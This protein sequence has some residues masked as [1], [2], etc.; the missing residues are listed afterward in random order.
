MATILWQGLRSVTPAVLRWTPD[1][2]VGAVYTLTTNAK[3][4][5][6]T[7]VTGNTATDVAAGIAAAAQSSAEPEWAELAV[8]SAA[9]VLSVTGP[10]DGAPITVTAGVTGGGS[11]TA[12]TTT[13]ATSPHD[14][15]DAANYAGGALPANS[16]TLVFPAQTADVRYR[17][18]ALQALT[19]LTV[20]REVNGPAIGLADWPQA[21]YR[22]YRPTRLKVAATSIEV[23]LGS[24]DNQGTLRLDLQGTNSTVRI[25]STTSAG[26]TDLDSPSQ[27]EIVNSGATSTIQ[28]VASSLDLGVV[29][30]TI[31]GVALIN[32]SD[33]T[34]RVGT[35]TGSPTIELIDSTARIGS[36]F[37]ALQV[38]GAST[39][40]VVGTA[41]GG[42]LLNGGTVN[43][44]GRGVL[45]APVVGP[46]AVLD[47]DQGVDPVTVT[48][49]I[50]LNQGAALRDRGTRL[51]VPYGVDCSRSTPEG[52]EVGRHRRFTVDAVP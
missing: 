45:N 47:L 6:Y 31:A 1:A 17:L 12:G 4:I 26:R 16:D 22:E 35:V 15:G 19:G 7:C 49:R 51:V 44:I 14:L 21:F 37:S 3:A 8:D 43:W 29:A 41:T 32:A 28:M 20:R 11:L 27:V 42:L 38:E 48:G 5:S 30:S 36:S 9:A 23:E 50:T 13:A 34:V 2:T 39:V 10:S 40:E 25:R 24:G 52:L 46:E 33:S 18:D